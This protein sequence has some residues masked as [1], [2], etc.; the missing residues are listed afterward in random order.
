MNII[1][2]NSWNS[3]IFLKRC[4]G[5]TI[6]LCITALEKLSNKNAGGIGTY[7]DRIWTVFLANTRSITNINFMARSH[8]VFLTVRWI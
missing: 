6:L 4:S 2:E 5:N 8:T 1:K 3:Q 7:Y